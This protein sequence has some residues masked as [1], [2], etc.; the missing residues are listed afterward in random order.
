[1]KAFTLMLLAH[2]LGDYYFQPEKLANLKSRNFIYVLLHTVIYAAAML[3]MYFI[4]PC[5]AFLWA[6]TAAALSHLIIDIIKQLIINARA[7]QGVLT[8][9]E[10]RLIYIIDQLLHI[11]V[12]LIS[13]VLTEKAGAEIHS[14][15]LDEFVPEITG[16]SGFKLIGIITALLLAMKPANVFI[17]KLLVTE[18]PDKTAETR[19]RR[20][21]G[22]GSLERLIAIIM[23]YLGQY[24]AVALVFTAK[25]IVRFK[26]FEDR[27]FAEYYLTGTLIS[28]VTALAIFFAVT[29]LGM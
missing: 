28:V 4:Y 1:M 8:V 23:L 25:S 12:I 20:G 17:R 29:K 11:A 18:K 16:I 3:L 22:I 26:A 15:F 27:D 21:A 13:A 24:A 14:E 19:L 5:R 7:K 9:R 10:E 6:L 2:A